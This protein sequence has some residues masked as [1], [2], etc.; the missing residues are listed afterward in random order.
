MSEMKYSTAEETSD[1]L[2]DAG[3]RP[4][5]V[6]DC[7][8]NI[9]V[10]YK[11]AKGYENYFDARKNDPQDTGFARDENGVALGNQDIP[12][13]MPQSLLMRLVYTGVL[14]QGIFAAKTMDARL[15]VELVTL[16][17]AANEQGE[18]FK[19]AFL[20]SRDMNEA[21][22]LFKASGV[23]N[24]ELCT[25]VADSGA[26]MYFGGQKHVLR[27]VP[28]HDTIDSET[29]LSRT[30]KAFLD[31]VCHDLPAIRERALQAL[32]A[33]GFQTD[34]LP[35]FYLERKGVAINIHYRAME[36]Q[37]V[38]NL[39]DAGIG[40][41]ALDDAMDSVDS[42]LSGVIKE[43]LDNHA[44]SG[45]QTA[46]ANGQG[47]KPVFKSKGGPATMELIIGGVDKGKGLEAII[48]KARETG[49]NISAFV[50]SGD[51][52]WKDGKGAGTDYDAFA[53]A[54]ELS[55][56]YG[57]PVKCV[58]T[59]H[60]KE[61]TL[62]GITPDQSRSIAGRD[63]VKADLVM[64]SPLNNAALIINL[65]EGGSSAVIK[66]VVANDNK[67]SRQGL[68]VQDGRTFTYSM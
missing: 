18:P 25:L 55:V 14:E 45:P 23:K 26:T 5:P 64:S 44:A 43:A 13:D 4:C 40:D 28:D 54:E 34:D 49:T 46:G 17:N 62:H 20:T 52:V 21:V 15:P 19:L 50:F 58:L 66:P 35:D 31:S 1:F 60:P 67:G 7:D 9:F 16:I 65:A 63:D 2:R 48:E 39:S 56:A 53:R 30:E 12:F 61:E 27:D 10:G 59:L 29:P 37:I 36:D 32:A 8:G 38:K 68:G 22:Q 42:I 51:D 33:Q 3:G 11:L 41:D 47:D 24:P 6:A 57:V